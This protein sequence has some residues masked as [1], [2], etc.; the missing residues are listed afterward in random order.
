MADVKE[1]VQR[2][3][4]D[5]AVNYRNSSVHASGED[6]TRMV[7]AAGLTG[8]EQV[9]DAGCG[10]GHTALAFAPHAAQVVAYDLTPSM[11]VQV[12]R[13]AAERGIRNVAT[14]QGDVEDLPFADAT[15]N[16]VVSRYSAHH[17]PHPVVALREF[18]RVLKP[19][20]RFILSDIVAADAPALDTFLQTIELL[21]DPSHVRD[22][23]IEQW[24]RMFE[25]SNFDAQVIFTW[26]LPL[27]FDAWVQRMATPALN[28]TMIKTLFDGAPYEVREAMVV[29]EDYTFSI[30]GALLVGY[31]PEQV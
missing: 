22:H 26:D 9:L 4:S 7:E 28:V 5:V 21:R 3:F 8:M 31:K 14:R 13:L 29:Q 19:G 1:S 27:N 23:S 17:W 18:N 11:L 20:G 6:L 15:F 2:Q 24:L 16:L 30:P 10:P 25:Q 12:E